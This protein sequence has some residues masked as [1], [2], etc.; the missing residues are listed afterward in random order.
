MVIRLWFSNSQYSEDKVL[1]VWGVYLSGLMYLGPNLRGDVPL[2]PNSLVFLM[3]GGYFTDPKCL[4]VN[5]KVRYSS[6]IVNSCDV[7]LSYSVNSLKRYESSV[8]KPLL[9]I[10]SRIY[11]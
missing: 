5:L 3:P 11:F 9:L 6:V 2:K 8:A 1:A 7:R 4:D 10:S